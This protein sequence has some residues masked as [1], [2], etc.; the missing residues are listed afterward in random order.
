V[1]GGSEDPRGLCGF[2][3]FTAPPVV[4]VAGNPQGVFEVS[5]LLPESHGWRT[6]LWKC[7]RQTWLTGPL[8]TPLLDILAEKQTKRGTLDGIT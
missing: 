2:S 6:E 5:A 7:G 4:V 8:D 1:V 3:S